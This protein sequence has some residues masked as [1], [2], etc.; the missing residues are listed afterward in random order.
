MKESESLLR[1]LSNA[2]DQ[3]CEFYSNGV[4]L[5]I[6]LLL[7]YVRDVAKI[8]GNFNLGV[9]SPVSEARTT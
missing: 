5:P 1:R 3:A 6:D 4:N 7:L 9:A 8:R 2:V